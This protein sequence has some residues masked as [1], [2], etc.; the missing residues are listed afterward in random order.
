M[1]RRECRH[2]FC[3]SAEF[4]SNDVKPSTSSEG[5]VH[6]QLRTP[7]ICATSWPRVCSADFRDPLVSFEFGTSW[8][9]VPGLLPVAGQRLLQTPVAMASGQ[10]FLSAS[11]LISR[12]GDVCTLR[13]SFGLHLSQPPRALRRRQACRPVASGLTDLVVSE[14]LKTL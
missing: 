6:N 11:S 7:R 14:L 8:Y 4:P 13:C 12:H 10:L 1:Q 3:T 5:S 9:A 2:R